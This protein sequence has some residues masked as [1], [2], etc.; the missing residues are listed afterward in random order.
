VG[1]GGRVM[2]LPVFVRTKEG[3]GAPPV[4]GGPRRMNRTGVCGPPA[5]V[6]RHTVVAF[7]G[8]L[9]LWMDR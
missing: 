3:P 9:I 1:G 7:C 5:P 8:R 2:L 4:V 6:D